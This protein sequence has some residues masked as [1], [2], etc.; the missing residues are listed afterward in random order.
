M[1]EEKEA[2]DRGQK[3]QEDFLEKAKEQNEID[4][5]NY[6]LEGVKNYNAEIDDLENDINALNSDRQ[7]CFSEFD[8]DVPE[9][10]KIDRNKRNAALGGKKKIEP[11][12]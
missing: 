1:N 9:S 11:P 8:G 10:V 3:A 4:D 5:A 7:Q 12:T 6:L 2:L